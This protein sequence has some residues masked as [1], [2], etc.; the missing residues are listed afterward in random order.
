MHVAR[1]EMKV[2]FEELLPRI[3]GIELTGEPRWLKTNFVGGLRSMP[4]RL[5]K[6]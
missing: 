5:I 1:L 4:V 2:L 6:A 3:R